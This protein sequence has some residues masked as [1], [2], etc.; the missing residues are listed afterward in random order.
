MSHLLTDHLNTRWAKN[1]CFNQTYGGPSS[2]VLW[3]STAWPGKYTMCFLPSTNKD[4][5]RQMRHILC[6]LSSSGEMQSL[7]CLQA[8]HAEDGE[9]W[10]EVSNVLNEAECQ[11]IKKKSCL[12]IKEAKWL[13]QLIK[14]F[15]SNIWIQSFLS[16][17]GPSIKQIKIVLCKFRDRQSAFSN[18]KNSQGWPVYDRQG[19]RQRSSYVCNNERESPLASES[20]RM[21]FI[22]LLGNWLVSNSGTGTKAM[23]Q[24]IQKW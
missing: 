19:W 2:R 9:R 11:S 24:M 14:G 21:H 8:I 10:A 15:A 1:A 17:Q 18:C 4:W 20:K 3:L 22:F 5:Q 12:L 16:F 13:M 7:V 23:P 6:I